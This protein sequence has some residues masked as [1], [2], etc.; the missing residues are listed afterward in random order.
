M[1]QFDF[2]RIKE[3]VLATAGRG[4]D[5]SVELCKVASDKA[6]LMGRITK[7]KTEI[8]ME[9]DTLRKSYAELGK[10]YHETHKDKPAAGL[11]QAVSEISLGLETVA[12]KEA[13]V[14]ALKQELADN[15][16]EVVEDVKE[17]AEDAS[18]KV[19]D[20]AEDVVE[21]AKDAVKDAA[22]KVKDTAEKVEEKVEET[23]KPPRK[24][25]GPKPKPKPEEPKE[26]KA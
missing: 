3:K 4:L 18:E 22:E 26:P 19:K 21:K 15:F 14:K 23:P 16:D 25:P 13:E 8:A 10:L 1:V 12:C 17:K 24:K 11:K 7:L 2:D 6:K 9:K 20:V 5:K